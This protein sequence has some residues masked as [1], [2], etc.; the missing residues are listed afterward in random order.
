V[1]TSEGRGVPNALVAISGGDLPQTLWTTTN[2]FGYYRFRNVPAGR[3][4]LVSLRSK[5]FLRGEL[6]RVVS[7]F[8]E[9]TDFDLVIET[10]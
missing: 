1:K 9:L 5:R 2:S 7:V 10:K 8:D 6:T 3:S 4:Y